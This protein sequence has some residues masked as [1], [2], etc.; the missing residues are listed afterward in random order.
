MEESSVVAGEPRKTESGKAVGL[1]NRAEADTA[2]VQVAGGRKARPGMVFEFAIDLIGEDI[3]VVFC[4][5][6][7]DAAKDLGRHH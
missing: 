4:R 6:I 3:D 1:A 5:Q 7:E 2:I